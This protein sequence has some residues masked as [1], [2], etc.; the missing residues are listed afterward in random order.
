MIYKC[1]ISSIVAILLS[2]CYSV[3][4]DIDDFANKITCADKKT[5]LIKSALVY[6]AEAVFVP[7]SQSLQVQKSS[8]TVVIQFDNNESITRVSIFRIELR[9][10]GL[11]RRQVAPVT[12]LDCTIK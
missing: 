8:E 9:F 1:I 6:Q 7:Q 12:L 2:G 11:S 10:M 5:N 4:H 3:W